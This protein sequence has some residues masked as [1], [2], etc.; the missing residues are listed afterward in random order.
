VF[1]VGNHTSLRSGNRTY[2][3]SKYEN[4]L[5]S[6]FG[7]KGDSTNANKG[8]YTLDIKTPGNDIRFN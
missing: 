2:S 7:I 1:A 4:K 6:I 8:L 5:V 3:P